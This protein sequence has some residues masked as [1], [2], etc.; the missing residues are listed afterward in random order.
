MREEDQ[1][2]DFDAAP[3]LHLH[4]RRLRDIRLLPG[5][6][7]TLLSSSPTP[8][9]LFSPQLSLPHLR[10][11]PHPPDILPSLPSTKLS[12]IDSLWRRSSS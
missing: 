9:L 3:P 11:H 12:S 5:S 1:D 7:G 10:S 2:R 8:R 6:R 4:L